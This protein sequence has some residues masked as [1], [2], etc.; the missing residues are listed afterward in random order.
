[1]HDSMLDISLEKIVAVNKFTK[2]TVTGLDAN[3][4]K[5]TFLNDMPLNQL[6]DYLG[7]QCNPNF[8]IKSQNNKVIGSFKLD[9]KN[10]KVR[11]DDGKSYIM[12]ELYQ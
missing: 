4:D 3:P 5:V 9:E 2:I 10:I 7:K 8:S 1:M 12:A 6:K 11:N